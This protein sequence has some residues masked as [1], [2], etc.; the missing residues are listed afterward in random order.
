ME[1]QQRE[2]EAD[3]R[4]NKFDGIETVEL[5]EEIERRMKNIKEEDQR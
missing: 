4:L 2:D 1:Q 5:V 3:G